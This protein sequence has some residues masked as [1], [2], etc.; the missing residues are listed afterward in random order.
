MNEKLYGKSLKAA[1]TPLVQQLSNPEEDFAGCVRDCKNKAAENAD[2]FQACFNMELY[3][4]MTN[5]MVAKCSDKILA[6]AKKRCDLDL[7]LD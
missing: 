3:Q 5:C 6:C 7:K 1:D 2:E 4:K